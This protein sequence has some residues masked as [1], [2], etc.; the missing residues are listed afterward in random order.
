MHIHVEKLTP[1][2]YHWKLFTG[3]G[4]TYTGSSNTFA[5]AIIAVIEAKTVSELETK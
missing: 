5:D 4:E 3:S 2:C 1:V